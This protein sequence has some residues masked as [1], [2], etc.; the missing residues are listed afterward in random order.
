MAIKTWG[1]IKPV[2]H[3]SESRNIEQKNDQIKPQA[4][5]NYVYDIIDTY[6][7]SVDIMIEAKHKELAV[8]KYLSLNKIKNF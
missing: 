6:G 7:H 3:Y 5:S 8:L 4:H 1:N 2:V